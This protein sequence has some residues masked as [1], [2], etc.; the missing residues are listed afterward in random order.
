MQTDVQYSMHKIHISFINSSRTNIN[1]KHE[2]AFHN[3]IRNV[4]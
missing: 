1:I 2:L 3:A 4:N